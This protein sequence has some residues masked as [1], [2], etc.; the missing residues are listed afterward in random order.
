MSIYCASGRSRDYYYYILGA[1]VLTGSFI[2]TVNSGYR[3]SGL[4]AHFSSPPA[5]SYA[6]AGGGI[7]KRCV[8]R[9][10]FEWDG[11][12]VFRCGSMDRNF[13]RLPA[14]GDLGSA[15]VPQRLAGALCPHAIICVVLARKPGSSKKGLM[16]ALGKPLRACS[17]MASLSGHSI[18][19]ASARTLPSAFFT[20]TMLFWRSGAAESVKGRSNRVSAGSGCSQPWS[21]SAV[22]ARP[23][24][25]RPV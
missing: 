24:S 8:C 1:V 23:C 10:D 14:T 7:I 16:S 11:P 17:P 9:D 12:F 19:R 5:R 25:V 3:W 2:A 13:Q 15:W 21:I 4:D 20:S 18:K 6:M 22:I